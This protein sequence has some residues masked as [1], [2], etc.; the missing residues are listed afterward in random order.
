MT[1]Q[2]Q[3]HALAKF[4]GWTILEPEIC[5]AI[6]YEWAYPPCISAGNRSIVPSY[7]DDLNEINEFE[8]WLE[9]NHPSR[10]SEYAETLNRVILERA[11]IKVSKNSMPAGI[12]RMINVKADVKLE[13]LVKTLDLWEY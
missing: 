2:K 9:Q 12:F 11:G 5:P 8:N 3:R 6:T 7:G 1:E 10:A 13:A 4:R